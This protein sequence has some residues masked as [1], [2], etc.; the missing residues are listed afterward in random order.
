[1]LLGKLFGSNEDEQDLYLSLEKELPQPPRL[2][3]L[4]EIFVTKGSTV[5]KDPTR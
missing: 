2:C 5:L 1:M 4:K 3:F